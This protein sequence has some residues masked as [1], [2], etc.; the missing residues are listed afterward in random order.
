MGGGRVDRL[1]QLA[2]D[3]QRNGSDQDSEQERN[4]PAPGIQLFTRQGRGE[5]YA[6]AGAHDRRQLLAVG[7]PRRQ[8]RALLRR[9]GL[10]QIRGCRPDFPAAREALNQPG[11]DQQD[12]RR[13]AD[14]GVRRRQR[15]MPDPSAISNSV[16]VS[17]ARRPTRSAYGPMMAAP[18]GRVTN[19]TPKVASAP[20]SRPISDSAGR[21]RR[22][23]SRRRRCRRGSRRTRASYR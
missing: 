13:D 8:R 16:R 4:P 14:L 20:S 11:D 12:R 7:L 18:S 9:R 21:R 23:S 15:T 10:E 19:P 22:R 1:R 5:D 3:I 2:S 6:N 17:A